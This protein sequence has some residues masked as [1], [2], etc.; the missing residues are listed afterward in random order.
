MSNWRK[1]AW[2]RSGA[3]ALAVGLSL[4]AGSAAA[5]PLKLT[6][7]GNPGHMK[8]LTPIIDRFEQSHPD[9]QIEVLAKE[10]NPD[11]ITAAAAAGTMPDIIESAG[12]F[13]Q[14]YA[15]KGLMAPLDAFVAGE[16]A[17]FLQ[18]FFPAAMDTGN[19]YDGKLY[20]LP[21]FLQIEGGYTNPDVLAEAG[22]AAPKPGWTW[23]DLRQLSQKS[24]RVDA[25]GKPVVWGAVAGH[26]LQFDVPLLGQ[27]GAELVDAQYRVTA[28][29]DA[30]KDV[31]NWIEGMLKEG[32]LVYRCCGASG[33][34]FS[35]DAY[36]HKTAFAADATYRQ[37][38]W[39]QNKSPMV[40]APPLR[41][42]AGSPPASS[43]STRS[44]GIMNV[45]P[46]RQKAAWTLIRY[47]LSAQVNSAFCTALGY[48][49]ATTSA[50]QAPPFQG[51]LLTHKNMQIWTSLYPQINNAHAWPDSFGSTNVR[52]V[53]IKDSTVFLQQ[54]VS[55]VQFIGNLSAH[56]E[57][58]AKDFLA[59]K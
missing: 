16:P 3:A 58:T 38:F 40:T 8:A 24:R 50:V 6:L 4:A 28:D 37:D 22:V 42:S 33:P 35:N 27:A 36:A 32:L 2:G 25:D 11:A 1:Q 9:I 13:T 59:A 57:A 17:G 12:T 43:F 21:T 53:F 48:P 44:W 26:P 55:V 46:E 41:E 10:M 14:Q 39:D 49:P 34:G 30:V 45:S 19:T 31:Y 7:S 47:L 18:D 5:A 54:K 15:A 52:D 56:L 51:Y 23:A 29:S 20:S